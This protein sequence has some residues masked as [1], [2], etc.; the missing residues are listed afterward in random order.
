MSD[1]HSLIPLVSLDWHQS[2][3]TAFVHSDVNRALDSCCQHVQIHCNCNLLAA[4][5]PKYPHQMLKTSNEN[6]ATAHRRSKN[7]SQ[8]RGDGDVSS[9]DELQ[10]SEAVRIIPCCSCNN[11]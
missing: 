4:N 7:T 1:K 3:I 11:S 8:R 2:D 5:L 6:A 10:S 9:F